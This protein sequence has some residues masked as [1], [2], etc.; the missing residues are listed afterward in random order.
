MKLLTP[1]KNVVKSFNRLWGPETKER[2]AIYLFEDEK[3][4]FNDGMIPG[5]SFF[6]RGDALLEE[7]FNKIRKSV[8]NGKSPC[9]QDVETAVFLLD[10]IYH[11][12]LNNHLQIAEM[13]YKLLLY[14]LLQRILKPREIVKESD[15]EAIECVDA[16]AR[17]G[18]IINKNNYYNYSFSTKF[19]HW[20]NPNGFPI[21]DSIASGLLVYYLCSEDCEDIIRNRPNLLIKKIK[22]AQFGLEVLGK[23]SNYVDAYKLFMK[24]YK[25]EE[26]SLKE[27]DVFLWTYGK[28]LKHVKWSGSKFCSIHYTELENN[29]FLNTF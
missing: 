9:R 20:L 1:N 28:A 16:I 3:E 15:N 10:G 12:N 17:A 22:G 8:A 29:S 2:E 24:Q 21:Y 5:I 23:Y 26:C 6:N 11:T 14:G 19:C 13:V 4:P 7:I 18:K 27:I 25:L